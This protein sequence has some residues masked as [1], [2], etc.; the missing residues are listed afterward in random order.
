MTLLVIDVQKGITDERLF[1]FEKVKSNIKE[2]IGRA[3]QN[4][5]EVIFVQHDDG[6]G[7]G[8]S[9]GDEEYEIHEEFTPEWNEKIYTK[10]VN[11]AL[12]PSTKL[13]SYLQEKGEDTIM[14]VGLQTNFCIDATIRTGFDNGLEVIVPEYT[15]STFDNEYMDKETCYHYYN[16]FLWPTRFAKCVSMEEARKLISQ[17]A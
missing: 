8:F 5:K 16:E 4:H 12:H 9:V 1:E 11:S 15:N 7:S 2:L 13:L 14:V 3:R 10:S 6:P 17:P